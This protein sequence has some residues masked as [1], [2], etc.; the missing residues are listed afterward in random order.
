MAI[1]FISGS[2]DFLVQR[3]SAQ[4]WEEIASV[5]GDIDGLEIVDGHAGNLDE[6]SRAVTQFV[7]AVQTISMFSPQKGVWFK[8]ITFLA[9]SVTGRAAG[10]A[11]EVE[12]LQACLETHDD[13]NVKIVLAAAPIDRRKKFYKWLQSNS[14][15]EFIDGGTDPQSIV[16]LVNDEAKSLGVEF[17]G[18]AARVLAEKVG[19]HTRLALEET[20]KL[21]T[22]VGKAGGKI[23][24]AQVADLVP[25]LAESDFFEATEAFFSLDLDKTLT[26]IHRHFFAGHDSRPLISSLQNRNRLMLQLKALMTNGALPTRVNQNNLA[27]AAQQFGHY[28]E[29]S[30]AKNSFNVFSQN[31]WYLGKLAAPLNRLTLRDLMA[32]HEAFRKAFMD[33]ISRPNEQEAVMRAMAISC[34]SSLSAR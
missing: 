11:A 32:F 18:N 23:T 30:A 2:D 4:I 29:G 7:T 8:N 26:A 16:N 22:Y 15:S 17:A 20:R 31:P 10:T 1:H 25:N 27:A 28:F 21:A 34:L 14:Q 5:I 13:A 19:S 6:V 12:R 24:S 9:D 3:K 33:I